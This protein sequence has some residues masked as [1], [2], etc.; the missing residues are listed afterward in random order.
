MGPERFPF[1]FSKRA[2]TI[3]SMELFVKV[4]DGFATTH[5]ESTI[6]LALAVGDKA[7]LPEDAQPDDVLALAPWAGSLRGA[8][9]FDDALG[10]WTMNAW[11][12]AG[13]G[14]SRLDARA[15]DDIILICHYAVAG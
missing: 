11:L 12:E 5:N 4:R 13:E 7:P 15:V 6:K 9:A 10:L 3:S 14:A 2:L 1:I 8:R